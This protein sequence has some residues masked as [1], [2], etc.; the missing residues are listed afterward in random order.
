VG[1]NDLTTTHPSLA[2]QLDVTLSGGLRSDQIAATTKRRVMWRCPK[3]HHYR[4]SA[5]DRFGSLEDCRICSG[6]SLVAGI[7]DLASTH[8]EI[9]K[10]MNARWLGSESAVKLAS[11]S[12]RSIHFICAAGRHEYEM[13]VVDAANGKACP[14][15]E[16]KRTSQSSENLIVTHPTLAAE[17]HPSWNHGREPSEARDESNQEAY[18][19]CPVGH[20]YRMKISDRVS[21][22]KCSMCSRPSLVP[23][24]NDIASTEPVLVAEFHTY[25]NGM[26]GPDRLLGGDRVF[27]WLCNVQKHKVQQTVQ[28]RRESEGCPE[29]P[30]GERLLTR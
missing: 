13:R 11:E 4:A 23:G 19:L 8:P 22:Y 21:G 18:W 25:L 27:W 6:R 12:S 17:W 1:Y 29:C 2:K 14:Q 9:A 28:Q 30:Q 26:K 16:R 7:N 24:V 15:C 5:S 10:L 3:G 20:T